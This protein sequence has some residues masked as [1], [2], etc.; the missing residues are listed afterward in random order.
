MSRIAGLI[1]ILAV[2]LFGLLLHLQNDQ[3]SRSAITWARSN[4]RCH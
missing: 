2:V 1:L 4:C 3:W